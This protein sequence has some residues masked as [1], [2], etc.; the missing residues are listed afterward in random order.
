MRMDN[1]TGKFRLAAVLLGTVALSAAPHGKAQRRISISQMLGPWVRTQCTFSDGATMRFGL[2]PSGLPH[3]GGPTW[4]TGQ[5]DATTLVVSERMR[6]QRLGI[7]DIDMR[8]GRYTVFVDSH[9]TPP[10][11]LIV[12]KR[13]GEWGISYPGKQYDLGRTQMGSDLLSHPVRTVTIGCVEHQSSPMFL[14]V[15]SGNEAGMAK[16]MAERTVNGKTTIAWK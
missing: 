13:S 6:F 1:K 3:S 9:G 14:W 10:W 5:Y 16:I 15:Q 7:V 12:S 2:M 8:P 11:T 4:H